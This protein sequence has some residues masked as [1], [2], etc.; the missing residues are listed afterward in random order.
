M[1]LLVIFLINCDVIAKVK[2]TR[3][4]SLPITNNLK[5]LIFIVFEYY[6]TEEIYAIMNER[7]ICLGDSGY[8]FWTRTSLI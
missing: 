2:I 3:T 7:L 4:T 6:P 5:M 8:Q 1:K